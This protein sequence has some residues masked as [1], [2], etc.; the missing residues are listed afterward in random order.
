MSFYIDP[1]RLSKKCAKNEKI[2]KNSLSNRFTAARNSN[3][4]V[5]STKISIFLVVGLLFQINRQRRRSNF[6]SIR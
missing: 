5:V 1:R 2:G 6:N 3:H 4:L